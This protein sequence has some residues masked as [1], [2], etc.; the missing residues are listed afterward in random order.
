LNN[1]SL[2]KAAIA[3]DLGLPNLD[4]YMTRS[5]EHEHFDWRKRD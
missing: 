1:P 2:D 4:K 3:R 5:G